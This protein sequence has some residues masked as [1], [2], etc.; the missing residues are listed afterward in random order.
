[1][2]FPSREKSGNKFNSRFTVV[3][4]IKFHSA[5]EAKR[6]QQ[7]IQD[8]KEGKIEDLMLQFRFPLV[9]GICWF[10]DFVYFDVRLGYWL[11]EEVK[12]KETDVWKIKEKLFRYLYP[13]VPLIITKAGK[14]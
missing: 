12:G 13:N 7:L 9:A 5:A 10:A 1:M 6:Y 11:V 14:V 8:L 2:R 3:D 4:G